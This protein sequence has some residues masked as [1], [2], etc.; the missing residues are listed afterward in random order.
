MAKKKDI[1]KDDK[2]K[3]KL[4]EIQKLPNNL[5][6]IKNVETTKK[7]DSYRA[8]VLQ[9][10]FDYMLKSGEVSFNLEGPA[11]F[12]NFCRNAASSEIE[13]ILSKLVFSI[14]F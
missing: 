7:S 8:S 1:L 3:S 6:E 5:W 10:L 4:L 13:K 14:L 2:I 12:E 11:N 9:Q